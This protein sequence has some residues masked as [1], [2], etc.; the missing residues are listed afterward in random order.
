MHRVWGV[1]LTALLFALAPAR[2]EDPAPEVAAGAPAASTRTSDPADPGVLGASEAPAAIDAEAPAAIDAEAAAEAAAPAASGEAPAEKPTLGAVGWDEQGRQGRIHVVARGDTLWD[3]SEAYLG[4]PW[5]WPP[6]WKDNDEDIANP[7]RIYP[8]DRI[9]ITPWE[10]RRLSAEEAEQ[11]L[12]RHPAE[13][14]PEPETVSQPAPPA[15]AVD[16]RVFHRESA[17]ETVGLVSEEV[18]ESAASIVNSV[19]KRVL[20][21]SGD[22]VYVGL[23]R[24]DVAPGDRFTIFRTRD[25]VFDPETGRML[26]WHVDLLGWLEVLEPADESA[27]AEIR[28]SAAEIEVGDRLMPR[29]TP[30]YDIAIGPSPSGVEGR[31][32]FFPNSR[33]QMGSQDF[34]YLNRGADDGLA[35]GSPLEVYRAGFDAKEVARDEKVRVPDRVVAQLLVIRAQPN[36]AVAV[37]RHTEEE[38]ALGDRFRGATR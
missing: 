8:G 9:W 16:E 10:M 21:G 12:A 36:S 1:S 38:L 32:S 11:M 28:L 15:L 3:I 35:V 5:V 27:L 7:H 37:V 2:A 23:G 29:E 17:E 18:L 22:R 30:Q 33:T 25:K 13:Q 20:L 24:E 34:V 26:G 31:I 6:I 14:A 19:P 4:T